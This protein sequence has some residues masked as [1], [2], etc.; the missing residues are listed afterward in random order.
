MIESLVDFLEPINVAFLSDDEGYKDTQIGSH[1][2]VYETYFPNLTDADVVLIGCN[3]SRG[4]G[5]KTVANNAANTVRTELYKLFQWHK[6]VQI[7]DV[8]NVKIGATLNDSYIA[9]QTVVKELL[10]LGKKVVVFG[11][12]HDVSLA[13]YNAYAHQEKIIEMTCVD[14]AIDLN[15]DSVLPADIFLMQI[16]T[17]EPNYVRHY[18]HIGF[19]SYLVHPHM[20]ET[21]D[22]LRFDC[23]RV[24]KVKE[25]IEEMEPIIRQSNMLSFDVSAIQNAHAPANTLTPNGFTGE[26]A[27]S[28]L[29]YAGLSSNMSSVGI[30]GYH[31]TADTQNLTAKQISHMIW[32]YIDGVYKQK[33]EADITDRNQF[34]EFTIAFTDFETQFLQSKKT[35]RW[36]MQMFDGKFLPCSRTDYDKACQNE[37]PEKW[38]RYAER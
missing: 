18:S 16:L 24:G 2:Q 9:V 6:H 33:L 12:S 26:E 38:M 36:W 8:G 32:Y 22:K 11:A 15:L 30:Y 35:G 14:A 17:G 25:A 5:P 4:V 19:Q 37:I 7:A 13:Q 3:E 20:L 1:I 21:I 10:Q 34:K 28:L 23:F 29:Q 31:S 27:C